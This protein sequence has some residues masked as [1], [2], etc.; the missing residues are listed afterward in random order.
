MYKEGAVPLISLILK[1]HRSGAQTSI[2]FRL[3]QH[4]LKLIML[5]V[6]AFD[7][8]FKF[9]MN[10]IGSVIT[11]LAQPFMQTGGINS[12]SLPSDPSTIVKCKNCGKDISFTQTTCPLCGSN[13]P[14]E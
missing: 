6:T 7:P 1:A 3:F 2:I 9:S 5:I 12:F 10:D 13:S 8:A 14:H 11:S 4:C